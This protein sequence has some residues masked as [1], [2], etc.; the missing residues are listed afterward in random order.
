MKE[1]LVGL[2]RQVREEKGPLESISITMPI[3]QGNV[4]ARES[5]TKG[6]CGFR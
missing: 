6:Q 4:P 5:Y 3:G 2:M 1:I